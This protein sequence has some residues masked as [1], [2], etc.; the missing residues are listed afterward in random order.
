MTQAVRLLTCALASAPIACTIKT[1]P[2]EAGVTSVE[3]QT[4]GD[5]CTA[6]MTELCQQGGSRCGLGLGFTLTECVNDNVLLCCTASQCS[7]KSQSPA[8]AV[9]ACKQAIDA[10]DC[11]SMANNVT[12]DLCV[13]VPKKQ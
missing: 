3:S 13:G 4:V 11:N 9:D 6:I 8:S 5:Q 10:E 7:A 12:P 1:I 2:N